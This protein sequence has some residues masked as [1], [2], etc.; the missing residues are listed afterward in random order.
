MGRN[1]GKRHCAANLQTVSIQFSAT[2]SSCRVL[3]MRGL[4]PLKLQPSAP[5]AKARSYEPPASPSATPCF[6]TSRSPQPKMELPLISKL[7]IPCTKVRWRRALDEVRVYYLKRQ[8]RQCSAHAIHVLESSR[9]L[10]SIS[11]FLPLSR[12]G[13]TKQNKTSRHLAHSCGSSKLHI[14]H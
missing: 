6:V 14:S 12:L 9:G 11:Y 3:D 8:Y 5:T 2:R 1:S 13:V 10:V 4:I 7:D